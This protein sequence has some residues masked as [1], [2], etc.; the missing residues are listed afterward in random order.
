MPGE[1]IPIVLFVSVA[2]VAILRP[3]T[4]RIGLM[5]ERQYEQRAVADDPQS[6]RMIQLLERLV[7]RMDQ[8][9]DRVE[10]AERLLERQRSASLNGTESSPDG[11]RRE[12][13]RGART[14]R[15]SSA[16]MD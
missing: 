1:L 16:G 11:E 13:P 2:A 5:I 15:Q 8:V 10:F 7:D 4:K 14:S 9:E 6:V 12:T 3:L